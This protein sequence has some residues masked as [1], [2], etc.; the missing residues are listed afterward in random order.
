MKTKKT[1]FI[2]SHYIL[3][4]VILLV[5]LYIQFYLLEEMNISN[6]TLLIVNIPLAIAGIIAYK[7]F[8]QPL[9][10][11]IFQ[12]E[13]NLDNKI[14]KTLHELNT[15]V[16]TILINIKMLQKNTTDEKTFQRLSR[17]QTACDDLLKLYDDM[18]YSIKKEIETIDLQ[19]FNL[20]EEIVQAKTKFDELI[21]TMNITV[22]IDVDTNIF[23]HTDKKGFDTI[24][25]NL[26]SNAIKYN[27]PNGY[28][29][30]YLKNKTLY[31]E[32][33]G[34]GID[35][36]NLFLV[37]DS[38]Y[39]ENQAT[40]GFGLGLSI[41]KEFCDTNKIGVNINSKE[42]SYTIISLDIGNIMI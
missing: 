12:S 6:F 23:I 16:A 31:I 10:E 42:E 33:S 2:I 36:K 13:K 38:F 9:F 3:I 35:P 19:D 21:A 5:V 25:N 11:N 39:Q 4:F 18:E 14:K 7:F 41:V 37:F 30:I 15:P 27:K 22:T 20:Y 34:I 28:I 17:I 29:K 8:S 24:I 1:D 26:I 32:D 40:K